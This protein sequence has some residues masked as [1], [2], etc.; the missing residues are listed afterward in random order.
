MCFRECVSNFI[1]LL[2]SVPWNRCSSKKE[3][4]KYLRRSPLFNEFT[5]CK[6]LVHFNFLAISMLIK[7]KN[8]RNNLQWLLPSTQPQCCLIFA[9]I[10]LQMLLRCCLIHI[11]FIILRHFL[12]LL[13]LY[14]CLDLGLFMSYLFMWCIF[15]FHLH[16][17]YD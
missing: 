16:F 11:S 6:P 13:Y 14:P 9:W 8:I 12:Y 15:H 3:N 5:D 17:L 7:W 10:E 1:L 2:S 4:K